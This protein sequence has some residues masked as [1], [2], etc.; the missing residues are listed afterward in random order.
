MSNNIL[1]GSIPLSLGSLTQLESLDL[2]HNHLSGE[3]PQQLGQLTFL[4]KFNVSHNNLTGPIPQ[5]TQLTTFDSTSYEGNPGLCGGPLQNK[6]G[7]AKTPQQPPSSVEQNDSGSAGAFEFDWKFVLAGLGSGLVVGVVLADV[8][9]T[10]RK[11]LFVKI[12]GMIRLMITKGESW[13]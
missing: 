2:S 7:V 9:I 11:E 12:V 13:E 4:G 8:A 3:I 10:R 5:G 6:C 1:T